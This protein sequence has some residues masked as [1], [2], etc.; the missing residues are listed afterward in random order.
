MLKKLCK[1]EFKSIARTLLPIYLA[2]I[3]VSLINAVSLGLSSGPFNDSR[4]Q[5]FDGTVLYWILGLMQLI[6]GFAYFAVLVALFVLTMV[7]I[8]QR[9]YKGLLCDEGYLM[10]TLPVKTWQLITAKGIAA[11]V[12]SVLSTITAIISIFILCIGVSGVSW[13][14]DLF[15]LQGWIQFFKA[16]NNAVPGWP[17]YGLLL[18]IVLIVSGLASLYQMYCAMA[19]GHLAHKH[20]IMMSIAAYVAINMVFSFISGLL[21]ILIGE[22][23][24]FGIPQILDR[25]S[26][27]QAYHTG[28]CILLFGMLLFSLIQ[29]AIFFFGTE[30]ILSR[31]LNLE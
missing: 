28:M 3:A 17:L 2:V 22:T 9:F 12:M 24:G 13:M 16:L 14:G 6:V 4:I 18:L 1:Y 5:I 26:H 8:L 31:R 20:R 27:V 21:M 15:H 7:V 23:N 30:R 29:F 10:F 25:M 19:I 11:F